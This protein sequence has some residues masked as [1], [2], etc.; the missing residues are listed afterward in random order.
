MARRRNSKLSLEVA[1]SLLR[2]SGL[3]CTA[4][5]V[6]VI[7]SLGDGKAPLSPTEVADELAEFGFD[8]STIY[9][10]LTELDEA[11]IV[12]RLDLGDSLRRFELLPQGG[13]GQ[14]EHPHFMCVD[15][16][17]IQC[18]AGFRFKLVPDNPTERTPGDLWEVLIK[19]RCRAC[20]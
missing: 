2:D 11:G 20:K 12:A 6:A 16:G 15:C 4:A 7:Q 9:R 19:G 10:S 13:D 5:R 14:S 17:K 3:R 8:K 18:L 1:K